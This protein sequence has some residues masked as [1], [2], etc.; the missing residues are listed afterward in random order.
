MEFLKL[1]ADESLEYRI[2]T[3]LR[4]KGHDIISIQELS[5][6]ISDKQ[7]LHL[8]CKEKRIILTNDKDFGDLVFLRK[9]KHSG[10]I[11]FRFKDEQLSNK[12]VALEQLFTNHL[13]KITGNFIVLESNKIRIRL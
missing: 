6:S 13:G 7:V 9:E 12:I 10:I 5:P 4:D 1:L 8:A 11:L 2:V 3:F